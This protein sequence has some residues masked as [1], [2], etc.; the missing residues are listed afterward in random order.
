MAMTLN[1]EQKLKFPYEFHELKMRY[2]SGKVQLN[3]YKSQVEISVINS[4]EKY[5][6]KRNNVFI[7]SKM[8]GDIKIM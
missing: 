2:F 6:K 1:I 5:I 4:L 7:Y 3:F 8:I